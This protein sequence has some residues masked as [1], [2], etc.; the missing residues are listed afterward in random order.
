MFKIS[1][2]VAI[3]LL[4]GIGFILIGVSGLREGFRAGMPGISCGVD[5]PGCTSGLQCMNGFCESSK[6]PSLLK[7][8]LPVYP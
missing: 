3:L 8:Q 7:N 4:I 2:K 5:H 1:W 6:S